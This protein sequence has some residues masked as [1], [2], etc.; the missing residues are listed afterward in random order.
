MVNIPQFRVGD[1]LKLKKPHPCGNHYWEV[2]RT[3]IDIGLRCIVC[4]RRVMVPRISLERRIK[5]IFTP[6][7]FPEEVRNKLQG[8]S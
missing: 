5:S 2:T 7:N 8:G 6:D 1:V 4:G 3:G